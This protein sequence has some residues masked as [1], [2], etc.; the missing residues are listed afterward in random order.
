MHVSRLYIIN[1][2]S[3]RELDLRFTKGKNVI[4]GRNNCGKSNIVKALHILLGE[5]SP[6]YTKSENITLGDFHSQNETQGD[7]LVSRSSNEIFIWCELTREEGEAL[8]YN[9]LNKCFGFY[10]AYDEYNHPRRFRK[11]TLPENFA[12]IFDLTDDTPWKQYLKPPGYCTTSM[13]AGD[14]F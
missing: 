11:A 12:D 6:T 7:T 4:I 3:I 14:D 1:Y 9:E 8:D 5:T 10:V 2:R 13:G